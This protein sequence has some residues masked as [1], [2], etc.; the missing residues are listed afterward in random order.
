MTEDLETPKFPKLDINAVSR[1]TFAAAQNAVPIIKRISILN[2]TEQEFKKLKL[3]MKP[4]PAF[5]KSKEWTIDRIPAGEDIQLGDLQ[6]TL[7]FS[8]LDGLNEAE[9]GQLTFCLYSEDEL[10]NERVVPIELLARDEWGGSAEMSQILAAFVS[11][12]H[13][14]TALILKEASRLLERDG[15]SGALNGYQSGDPR[16]AYMLAAAIWSAVSGMGLSYAQPPRSFEKQGQ[17]IRDPG[18]IADT[19]LATCLDSA[20]FLAA[21]FE[22]VKLNPAIVFTKDHA[23][24]G[25][26]L[27]EKTFPMTVESDVTEIRKAINSREFLTLETTLLTQRPVV[28][29]EQ[30]K[31]SGKAQLSEDREHDFRMA[32]DIAR[33][34][35]AGIRPLASHQAN[36]ATKDSVDDTV[37]PAS[38]PK[39]PSFDM[40][41][42]DIAEELPTDPSGRL[43]R[44][45]KKLLDLSLRNRLLNFSDTR[46]TL[47][48]VC[49]DVPSLEDA[50]ADGKRFRVISLKDENPVGNRDPKLY[51]QQTGRDIQSDFAASAFEKGQ[52][53]AIQ[54]GK[55]TKSRLTTL[56]RKAKSDMSE[57]G[58]NT[59]FMAVGFLRWK[60]SDKEERVYRAPLLLLPIKLSRRSAQSSYYISHHEDEVRFNQT[61]LEMLERDFGLMIPALR[62]DLSTDQS[63]LDIKLIFEI[64]Q[65][66]VREVPGFEV[67]QDISIST[68]SFAKY[69]MWKDLVDRTDSLK[70]NRLVRHLLEN[71]TE[72]F[73]NGGDD[74][75]E[76]RDIDERISPSSVYTPLPA[77]SSQLAAV[78]AAQAGK[79][80]VIIGPPGTGKSQTIANMI[81]H[82]LA[83]G[84]T[85]LFVA[86]KSAALDVVYRR[87][88]AYGLADACLELHS[89]KTDR[90]SVIA[91]LGQAWDRAAENTDEEW[92]RL[93]EDLKIK[94]DK[95]NE[96]V[97]ELHE[98]GSHGYSVF[99]AIGSLSGSEAVFELSFAGVNAHDEKSF[100]S[101]V[102]LAERMGLTHSSI[103]DCTALDGVDKTEWSFAWQAELLECAESFDVETKN[104][105]SACHA[106]EKSIGLTPDELISNSRLTALMHFAKSVGGI[107]KNDYR[108]AL[109]GEFE[110]VVSGIDD[111]EQSVGTFRKLH[112]Q[113]TASYKEKE[114]SRIPL[115]EID[116]DWRQQNAKLWP[117]SLLGKMRVKK[118]LQSYAADGSVDPDSEIPLLR[119]LQETYGTISA[120]PLSC[121][122]NFEG[123]QSNFKDMR[124]YLDKALDLRKSIAE[125]ERLAKVTSDHLVDFETVAML[126]GDSSELAKSATDL[127][128]AKAS[129]DQAGKSFVAKSGGPIQ[130]S[131]LQRVIQLLSDI[132]TN[133][134]R[135]QD[136]VKWS[137]VKKEA[138]ARGLDS[139]TEALTA[140][141]VQDSGK[142]FSASY[143]SWWLPL[144]I[145]E[146]PRLRSFVHWE[147][148]DQIE[149]FRELICSVQK[150]AAS[151]VRH[152]ISHGLPTRDGVPRKSELGMLRHQLGLQRPRTSIRELIEG[153]PTT[154]TQLTPC[155]LMSPLSVAQYLPA[156]HAIFDMVI[157]D[158]ASQITTW[159]AVGAI[160]R[161]KQS[162][163]VGDPKQLPPTNFFGR[164]DDEEDNETAFHERDLSSILDEATAAGLPLHQLNW[165]YRSRDEALIVFSNHHYY[166]ERLVTFP[167]PR[168]ASDAVQFHKV[169]GIYARGSGRTNEIE[170]KAIVEFITKRLKDWIKLDEAIRKTLG[171]ITFNA[172][173]QELILDLLDTVRRKSPE[174]EWFFDDE[175]EEPVIVKNLEN[176]QGDE[177]DVMIFSIT[178]G[179]DIAGKLKMDFGAINRDGGEKRLNVAVTRAKSEFHVFSSILAEDIDTNRGKGL[180]VLHL[181]NYLDYAQRGSIAL[182]AMDEG[183]LGPAE[184]PFEESVAE[185]LRSLGWEV[186][187]QI[188]VS[189]YR[190]DLAVVHPDHAG[191][192]LAGIECDGATYH[193]SATARDRDEIREGVLRNLG[194]EIL[195]IWSTDWFMRPDQAMERID[196]NLKTLLE[197]SRVK[198][199]CEEPASDSEV[200]SADD[201]P[202]DAA[203][204]DSSGITADI[205]TSSLPGQVSEQFGSGH[206]VEPIADGEELTQSSELDLDPDQFF[207]WGYTQTLKALVTEVVQE[208][209]PIRDTLLYRAIARRHGWQRAGRRIQERVI[210]CLGKNERHKEN[211]SIFI[212][213]AVSY[214]SVI[215]Y[216]SNPD[217]GPRDIP[218]AEILG[219]I[220]DNP[221]LVT[222]EDP[223]REIARLIGLGGLAEDTRGYFERCIDTFKKSK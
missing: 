41:P 172:P 215:P 113:L 128:L 79:D 174:L 106:L 34:R 88:K 159:D 65:Q 75:P 43:E 207:E 175:R 160:A 197:E 47:G 126:G 49:A 176:I 204:Q 216:R 153:M 141:L 30:A 195:R 26:W 24:V 171:V 69:L 202:E 110:A 211:G 122:P 93:T 200:T 86:E 73:Q 185:S 177:R 155:V 157:F 120:S 142:E 180:G 90:K 107:A 117:F 114:F 134:N 97:H 190:I 188:G 161:S 56:Y 59:L 131:S 223:A 187:T 20:L 94:R 222:S 33:A 135:L 168:T 108:V 14:Q 196:D 103:S 189:G 182:P 214:Q 36:T 191:A 16:R 54:T 149:R 129:F 98:K 38:L 156:D 186:R 28:G 44:W 32:I 96:Y 115:D 105:V 140:G 220:S 139:L 71:P 9:H 40:L 136:W 72:R 80:F 150:L 154:F 111:L 35:S 181:K 118:L 146:K 183:S 179:R 132:K 52:L 45:Q 61:L 3:T 57:G 2:E 162:I 125:I 12:N 143:F 25:V 208:Q 147:Q 27:V 112:S 213:A 99:D 11:P 193:S 64:M 95:L 46:Q 60:K 212:W 151:Q 205:E 199:E 198:V 123:V 29:F 87:L 165:H 145:D 10:L 170:A 91:Q 194:W 58:T 218:Q 144:A 66:A 158:E 138:K 67:V 63:G 51:R 124:E 184:S 100:S 89:N 19:G 4:Q 23:F 48:F 68:F 121:L 137:E 109:R 203:E 18:L 219:L 85:V 221:G 74:F 55:E 62:G 127:R 133:S 7:D 21:A 119:D 201:N 15:H 83:H 178:F 92:I 163:I 148:E 152:A 206:S 77:D 53:C 8:V 116:R 78:V 102:A 70:T 82:C 13:V 1:T 76:P 130:A 101:L 37:T 173:Q 50:L 17:K 164:T 210:Q 81:A 169:S 6:V 192:F 5:C 84:K 31:A 39:L 166:G 209:G 42:A 22:A 167:S 104:L 217:R